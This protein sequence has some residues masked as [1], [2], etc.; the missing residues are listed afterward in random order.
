MKS[1]STYEGSMQDSVDEALSNLLED[2]IVDEP[3]DD[4]YRDYITRNN[5]TD[6]ATAFGY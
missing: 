5:M 3:F 2:L 4:G 1:I 6:T